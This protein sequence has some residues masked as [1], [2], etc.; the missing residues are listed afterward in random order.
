MA[1]AVTKASLRFLNC[2]EHMAPPVYLYVW[3]TNAYLNTTRRQMII[4]TLFAGRHRVVVRN[5]YCV[6]S[7]VGFMTIM[8]S[9]SH[10][11][12]CMRVL[13][14]TQKGKGPR[15]LFFLPSLIFFFSNSFIQVSTVHTNSVKTDGRLCKS[16][17]C[18][19]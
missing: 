10:I 6:Y 16:E 17:K 2:S 7:H 13:C 12:I 1:G 4:C 19:S 11:K 8:F 18:G 15:K 3:R 14:S 9:P 5:S